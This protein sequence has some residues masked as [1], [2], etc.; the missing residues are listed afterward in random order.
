MWA[1]EANTFSLAPSR[2]SVLINWVAFFLFFFFHCNLILH[3]NGL[4]MW[5]SCPLELISSTPCLAA[6]SAQTTFTCESLQ[7]ESSR[8]KVEKRCLSTCRFMFHLLGLCQVTSSIS[9]PLF[10][11]NPLS[12]PYSQVDMLQGV[13]PHGA[14][15]P[16][17]KLHC[18]N[19]GLELQSTPPAWFHLTCC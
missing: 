7:A 10:Q 3:S 8:L 17:S 13:S 4:Q 1:L 5:S 6:H 9:G 11:R 2:Y 16:L 14:L 19:N 12:S 18:M 15:I